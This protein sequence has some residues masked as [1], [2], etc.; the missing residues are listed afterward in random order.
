MGEP[1]GT[2]LGSEQVRL[3]SQEELDPKRKKGETLKPA[4]CCLSHSSQ[5]RLTFVAT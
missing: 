2:L 3:S 5:P 4:S 1:W